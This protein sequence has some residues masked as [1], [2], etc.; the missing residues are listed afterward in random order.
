MIRFTWI[1]AALPLASAAL[2]FF[3]GKRIPG[4][5]AFIGIAAMGAGLVLSLLV[6]SQFVRNGDTPAA[7]IVAAW[8][9][10]DTG[11]GPAIA[12]GSQT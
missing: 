3:L 5:G 1:I 4:R 10:A 7:T 9:R 2:I 8:I 12:S 11:V 6:L